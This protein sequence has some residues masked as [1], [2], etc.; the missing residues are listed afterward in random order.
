MT[1]TL[2]M[3]P[4]WQ[5]S[6]PEH[7]QR[8][9]AEKYGAVWVEQDDWEN[10]QPGA[11]VRRL[12]EVVAATPGELVLVAHS[13]GV[14]TVALWARGGEVPERVRGALLVAPPDLEQPGEAAEVLGRFRQPELLPLPFPALLVASENDPYSRF[15]RAEQLAEG[16]AA[17]LVTAGEAGHI[18]V[19]SGHGDWSEGEV[20]L[21]EALHAWTPPEISRF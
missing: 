21:S 17:T 2:I 18:N 20:L 8:R 4:G 9:W 1:P 6:G 19:A 3:V 7:W 12:A 15:E 16:W 13:L 11:W 14:S 10:P 5:G